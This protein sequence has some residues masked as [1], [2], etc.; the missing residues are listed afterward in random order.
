[1][2][3][4]DWIGCQVT[5]QIGFYISLLPPARE[6]SRFTKFVFSE[7]SA[8]K[9]CTELISTVSYSIELVLILLVLIV[10]FFHIFFSLAI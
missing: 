1:M 7:S 2:F 4:L 5:N 8:I 6:C 3:R 10:F 9:S